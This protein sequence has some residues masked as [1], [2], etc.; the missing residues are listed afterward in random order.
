ASDPAPLAR[1]SHVRRRGPPLLDVTTLRPRVRGRP[2]LRLIQIVQRPRQRLP[3]LS[4]G[5]RN[6]LSLRRQ[7][8]QEHGTT[9]GAQDPVVLV[10]RLVAVIPVPGG[11]GDEIGQLPVA[12]PLLPLRTPRP[13]AVR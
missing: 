10:S 13:G 12:A 8:T 9:I 4:E 2:R 11:M 6:Q 5:V 1:V 7:I 3:D